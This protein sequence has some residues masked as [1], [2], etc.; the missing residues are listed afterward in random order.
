M[1]LKAR[2]TEHA[3]HKGKGRKSGHWGTRAEAKEGSRK[4][5]RAQ[6]RKVAWESLD[7]VIA[8]ASALGW[9]PL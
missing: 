5:R 3:G 7:E 2:K 9:N 6:G 1:A 4:L 8:R